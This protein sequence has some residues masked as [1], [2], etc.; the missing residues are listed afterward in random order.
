[1]RD[2]NNN[3]VRETEKATTYRKRDNS[4]RITLFSYDS[5]YF[6]VTPC[7]VYL[8]F[9]CNSRIIYIRATH[10][11]YIV[12]SPGFDTTEHESDCSQ[13]NKKSI[14]WEHMPETRRGRKN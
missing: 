11:Y 8:E 14:C 5:L 6:S 3:N 12:I 1:M 4:A 10:S 2:K 7:S 13:N 9:C